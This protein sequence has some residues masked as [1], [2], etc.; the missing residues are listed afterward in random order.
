MKTRSLALLLLGLFSILATLGASSTS[1]NAAA[2]WGPWEDADGVLASGVSATNT[3]A[4]PYN[5]PLRYA[6]ATKGGDGRI[7]TR[8]YFSTNGWHP[9]SNSIGLP[10]VDS[11]GNRTTNPAEFA[12]IVGT[13][14]IGSIGCGWSF[15]TCDS[16][17]TESVVK[18]LVAVRA[19]DN[20]LWVNSTEGGNW[21]GW[22]K[23]TGGSLT[24]SPAIAWSPTSSKVNI[25]VRGADNALYGTT[26]P[27]TTGPP[28]WLRLGGHLLGAPAATS[29]G[30]GRV[31]VF[32]RGGGNQLYTI[33]FDNGQWY[34]WG[35]LGGYLTSDPGVASWGAN[36]LDVFARGNDGSIFTRSW[37][38]NNWTPWGS[39]GGWVAPDDA[40]GVASYQHGGL[41]LFVRGGGDHMYSR[42]LR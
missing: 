20:N 19:A 4:A 31:D 41:G 21:V 26:Y 30:P 5:L 18:K 6:I 15:T 3:N 7:W 11:N 24:S 8:D 16:P 13:P 35:S 42:F 36:R 1:A 27:S 23:I 29:W 2:T 34:P 25:F 38:Y 10:P 28:T 9:W 39:L 33:A 32:A 12:P 22:W 14:A 37:N 17:W 40:P